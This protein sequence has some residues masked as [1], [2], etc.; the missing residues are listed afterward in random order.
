MILIYQNTSSVDYF[1][2]NVTGVHT[3]IRMR[4]IMFTLL[5]VRV[6]IL[7]TRREQLHARIILTKRR[8]LGPKKQFNLGKPGQ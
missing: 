5:Y 2:L 4:K 8:Y 6:I 7:L 1:I 3:D